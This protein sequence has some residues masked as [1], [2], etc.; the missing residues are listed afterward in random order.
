MYLS[1]S[2]GFLFVHVPKAAGTSIRTALE[3]VTVPRNRSPV[4]R[5]L[6]HLP[7]AQDAAR[8]YLRTHDTALWARTKLG[9]TQFDALKRYAVIRNPYD[10]AVSY[11]RFYQKEP[12]LQFL[13]KPAHEEF[14]GF[15]AGMVRY[16]RTHVQCHWVED[17]EGRLLVPGLLFFERLG[18]EFERFS[19]EV[20]LT[21]ITLGRE[22]V[23]GRGDYREFYDAETREMVEELFA[24]DF[25]RFGYAFDTGLP[26]WSTGGLLDQAS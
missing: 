8:V 16:G 23:S 4:Q 20:G 2:H 9:R 6:S 24:R 14:P 19:Q 7:Y 10:M 12:R 21:G 11:Y 17:R 15:V 25:R 3:G 13:S 5:V 22:N 26:D 1:L 18:E